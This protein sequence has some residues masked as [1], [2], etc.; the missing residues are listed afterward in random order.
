MALS[1]NPVLHSRTKHIEIDVH[2]VREKVVSQAL[3]VQHIPAAAQVADM[4]TKPVSSSIFE[5][6]RGKL[7][8]CPF[9]PPS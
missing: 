9:G 8:V 4:F 1:H 6:M 2:F 3:V 7:N 5:T